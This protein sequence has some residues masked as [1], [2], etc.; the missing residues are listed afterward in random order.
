MNSPSTLSSANDS[1]E[2]PQRRS[3]DQS[4]FTELAAGIFEEA[5]R[6]ST[7]DKVPLGKKSDD[8]IHDLAKKVGINEEGFKVI[9]K[10]IQK[11]NLSK[12]AGALEKYEKENPK[13]SEMIDSLI[14]HRREETINEYGPHIRAV[15]NDGAYNDLQAAE[16]FSL[17]RY[18]LIQSALSNY[19]QENPNGV[20]TKAIEYYGRNG[21]GRKDV[22]F[23]NPSQQLQKDLSQ[24]VT[25]LAL[26]SMMEKLRGDICNDFGASDTVAGRVV[27]LEVGKR[28]EKRVTYCQSVEFT[29]VVERRR[30]GESAFIFHELGEGR[31][32][33]IESHQRVIHGSLFWILDNQKNLAVRVM[34][35]DNESTDRGARSLSTQLFQRAE[36]PKK[37]TALKPLGFEQYHEGVEGLYDYLD[38]T[39]INPNIDT[40]KGT[41][42][43]IEDFRARMLKIAV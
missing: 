23:L 6:R 31:R 33:T 18:K 43:N 5:E 10:K 7:I 38:I 36:N 25:H 12:V 28:E 3:R 32:R 29:P 34:L 26:D 4:P 40:S 17:I 22:G 39:T 13:L 19:W 16:N 24:R 2:I 8:I 15:I 14:A 21:E 1:Q 41:D 37:H 20:I 11:L 35:T 27:D 30:V 9:I 42:N